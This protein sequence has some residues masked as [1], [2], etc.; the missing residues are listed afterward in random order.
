MTR[1]NATSR[2]PTAPAANKLRHI[3]VKTNRGPAVGARTRKSRGSSADPGPCRRPRWP[4]RVA[5]AAGADGRSRPAPPAYYS[6]HMRRLA[7]PIMAIAVAVALL[8]L[9]T[10]GVSHQ[11]T[12]CSIDRTGR[13][14]RLPGGAE[15]AAWSCRCSARSGTESLADFRGK[16]V[17]MNVF[18]SWCE[19]AWP[20][21]RCW[22]S[23]A[24][25]TGQ[26]RRDASSASPIWTTRALPS[27]SSSQY[28]ITY[29][30]VRDVSGNF[31]RAFG[32]DG[33]P[34][35]FVI[36]RQGRIVALRRYPAHAAMAPADRCRDPGRAAHERRPPR[37]GP[38]RARAR[39][40]LPRA[41]RRLRRR[42]RRARR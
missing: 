6:P 36:N 11:G 42:A 23:R 18:A 21:R 7:I 35:T 25:P 29:P 32:T 13:P 16:V 19:P 30:V 27:S 10:F 15:C 5:R 31:V 26:G 14:G 12:N 2:R 24:A 8:A 4:A 3:S 28:H 38:R 1:L 40:A 37:R 33:V 20:K 39:V 9:L 41:G 22:S 17:V 34:E